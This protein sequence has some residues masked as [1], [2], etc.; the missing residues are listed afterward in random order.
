MRVCLFI[1]LL[2][3]SAPSSQALA[4]HPRTLEVDC[5]AGDTIARAL[6]SARAGSVIQVRGTCSE[7]LSIERPVTLDG[8]GK[9]HLSPPSPEGNTFDIRSRGVTVRGFKLDGP[10]TFH[11]FIFAASEVTIESNEIRNAAN[12]GIS[13]AANS[14]VTLLDNVITGN[15]LGGV[16]GL[17]GVE[18]SIGTRIAFDPPSPNII[19]DNGNLGIVLVNGAGAQILGGNTISGHDIGIALWDAAQ[20]RVAGNIID[21]NNIGILVDGGGSLQLPLADNPVAAFTALNTG[22][23]AAYGIACKGGTI[24][25]VIDGLAPAIRLPAT[26]GALGGPSNEP[27][28]HCVDQ[29]EALQAP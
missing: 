1:C 18:Y 27:A 23:N 24:R 8:G 9:A 6:R 2:C 10:A 13:A 15:G 26:P 11:F 17:S 3:A 25:G 14:Q 20:A 12:F 19:A 28:T 7:S 16:I 22:D 21:G 5:D 29:S 4:L